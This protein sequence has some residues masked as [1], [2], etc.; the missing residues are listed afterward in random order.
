MELPGSLFA[1]L[2]PGIDPREHRLAE[3]VLLELEEPLG[4]VGDALDDDGDPFRLDVRANREHHH[5]RRD[6]LLKPVE[7]LRPGE[8]PSPDGVVGEFRLDRQPLEVGLL[9]L[10]AKA[11]LLQQEGVASPLLRREILTVELHGAAESD[12]QPEIDD[13][14]N[15]QT[16]SG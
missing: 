3:E 16:Q 7:Q 14:E 4:I 13:R 9:E 6:Y 1:A 12:E 8:G 5:R 15:G 2:A 11:L 10:P